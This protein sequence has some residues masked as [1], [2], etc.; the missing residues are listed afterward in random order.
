MTRVATYGQFCPVA[1]AVDVIGCRWALLVVREL[2]S[3]PARFGGLQRG[4]SRCPPATLAKRLR[5]LEVAGVVVR[6]ADRDGISY[7]LT[8]A[9]NE[10]Y[11][12]VEGLGTWGQRWARSSYPPDELDAE[13]LLWDVRRFLDPRGL[14]IDRTTIQLEVSTPG[15]S[16]RLF[17]M[18]VAPEGVDLC[19]VDPDRAVDV[20]VEA[21]LRALTRAWMGDTSLVEVIQEGAVVLRGPERLVERIPGWWGQHPVLAAID[22]VTAEPVPR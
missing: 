10:L 12:V 22:S 18:V 19:V 7:A 13:A 8:E 15:H 2:L 9:G 20:V 5:E 17:W 14:G 3:G 6:T 1:K 4:L 16:R 21:D 11:G